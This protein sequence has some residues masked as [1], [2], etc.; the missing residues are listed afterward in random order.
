MESAQ[1]DNFA[2]KVRT[3]LAELDEI[4]IGEHAG[5]LEKLHQVLEAELSTIDGL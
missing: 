5:H 1:V 3:D 4:P 2:D